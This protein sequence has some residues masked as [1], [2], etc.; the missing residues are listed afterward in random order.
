MARHRLFTIAVVVTSLQASRPVAVHTPRSALTSS[1]PVP[2]AEHPRPDFQREDWQN[3]NGTWQ[4]Q[5]D[6]EDAGGRRV[7]CV[8][9]AADWR[10]TAWLDGHS[11]GTHS[12]GYIPFEFEL[13]RYLGPGQRHLLVLRVDDAPR[14]FKL[15]GKQGYGNARGIW[16]TPYLE[17]RGS[18]PLQV[19]HFSPDVGRKRVVVTAQLLD[20]APR[21]LTLT[22][23][24][25]N[26]ELPVVTR[27]VPRG[28]DQLR[29]EVPIPNAHLWSLEDPF[30]YD[31]EASVGDDRVESYF[32]MRKIS[33]TTL[34]GT[35]YRYVALNDEPIYLQL[36][37]DQAFHP[38]GFYT[39]PSDS[40]VRAE[41]LRAK[42]IGLNGLREHV[43]VEAPRKL[44][45]ADRLGL[46]IMADVP[47]SWGEPDSAMR[48]EARST[49]RGMIQRDYNHPAIFAWVLFN[50]TWGLFTKAGQREVYRPETQTW[51]VSVYRE[52][53]TLDPTRLVEDN[54]PC[55]GRGH[56]ETDLNSW[57]AYLPG[58]EWERHD[59][60]VSD[61]TDPGSSWN[62]EAGY[63]QASP[64]QPNINSEFGNVWGYEGSTGDVDW[65]WDYHRAVN[66]FRRHPRIA[67]WLYTELHDVINEWNGYWRYDRSEKETGLGEL[68][69]GMSLLD[70]HSPLY[71]VVGDELSQSVATGAKV[72]V[73]LYA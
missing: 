60:L 33:V 68:V 35:D 52:A 10:T 56:T 50:E 3:L 25:K 21:D 4:F 18:I 39:Y 63:R 17:A 48:R 41:I 23:R 49:L 51:V 67:G 11:L 26:V 55:C 29:F 69:E 42:E 37:L 2:L 45:W 44:Y 40:F 24:F 13:T 12:G 30:L 7:F 72:R 71:V 34:P 70:L 66:A 14:A 27:R 54:S 46:L 32:G 47:N 65:S 15:E 57:H 28:T 22:L 1:P 38:E 59:Q 20:K 73:P 31:V 6:P 64:P 8:V 19:L 16:Q 36:A 53:K 62:F 9:G 58:W 43:K 5:F 61:S